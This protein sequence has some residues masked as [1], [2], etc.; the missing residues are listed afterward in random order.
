M[1]VVLNCK[2]STVVGRYAE[3]GYK[4]VDIQSKLES[5]N[6]IWIRKLVDD[7]FHAWKSITNAMFLD[8]GVNPSFTEHLPPPPPP[9][10]FSSITF[11]EN[12]LE[13]PNFA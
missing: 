7:N 13:A 8:T 3:G 2:H 1:G 12:N 9:K 4:D 6:I 10:G 11:E 5:L